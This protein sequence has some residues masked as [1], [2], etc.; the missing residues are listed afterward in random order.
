MKHRVKSNCSAGNSGQN[1][2]KNDGSFM[3][4][5]RKKMEEAQQGKMHHE[6]IKSDSPKT[7]SS[8]YSVSEQ[9]S[10][11]HSHKMRTD[12][13]LNTDTDLVARKAVSISENSTDS[14]QS[15]PGGDT[16][17]TLVGLPGPTDASKGE[18][19]PSSRDSSV[20]LATGSAA[21]K[22]SLLSFVGFRTQLQLTGNSTLVP[23]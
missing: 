3:E 6:E 13:S 22:S 5:F 1:V 8:K 15:W 18:N 14:S 11:S 16:E 17:K 19:K 20:A 23:Q 21:K 9:A 2:F 10:Q 12:L 7:Q 4:L